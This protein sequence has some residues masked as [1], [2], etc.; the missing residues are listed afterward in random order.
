MKYMEFIRT[1]PSAVLPHIPAHLSGIQP[2]QPFRWIIQFNFGERRLHYEVGRVAHSKDLELAYHFESK[3][4]NLN[5]Y[6]L[7]GFRRHL[8]EIRDTLG[9]QIQAEMWDRGWTKIY[10]RVP[11][12]DFS[13]A[14]YT[15]E[16]QEEI[17]KRLARMITCLQPIFAELRNDVTQIHR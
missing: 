5:R 16:Y 2:H 17:G 4:K 3:D 10:E 9:P 8:F 15:S 14:D 7:T 12:A 13:A 11:Q 6:L 1:M